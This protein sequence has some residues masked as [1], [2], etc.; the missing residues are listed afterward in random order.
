M[1]S[2]SVYPNPSVH[3]SDI[4]LEIDVDI[5]AEYEYDIKIY[6]AQGVLLM[7]DEIKN[8]R[9][10]LSLSDHKG[11]LFVTV[12]LDGEIIHSEKLIKL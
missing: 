6:S 8:K 1:T 9:H 2:L 10:T 7:E 5:L 12:E 3:N 4:T 11:L